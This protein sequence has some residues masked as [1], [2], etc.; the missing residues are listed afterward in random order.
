[1]GSCLSAPTITSETKP[2]VGQRVASES[3]FAPSTS[4][5]ES[6]ENSC[7]DNSAF[8][9]H[10]TRQHFIQ[11]DLIE[12]LYQYNNYQ[13]FSHYLTTHFAQENLSFIALIVVFRNIYLSGLTTE[14]TETFKNLPVDN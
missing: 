11:Q 1:M 2:Y 14:E 12:Y 8:A 4:G 6:L 13:Q 5:T 10:Q 3:L 7:S 9:I